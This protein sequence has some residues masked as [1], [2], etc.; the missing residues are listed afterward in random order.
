MKGCLSLHPQPAASSVSDNG[1]LC[2]LN[3]RGP[4]CQTVLEAFMLD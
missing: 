4:C 2:A 3:A 1:E